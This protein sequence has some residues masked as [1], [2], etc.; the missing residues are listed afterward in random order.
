M[1]YM[2]TEYLNSSQ[3]TIKYKITLTNTNNIAMP[4]Q[5]VGEWMK[6]S[7]SVFVYIL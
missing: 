3:Y 6:D 4:Q 5:R 7:R 2:M 1:Y